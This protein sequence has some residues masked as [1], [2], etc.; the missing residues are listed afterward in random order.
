LASEEDIS[1]NQKLDELCVALD[2]RMTDDVR[3]VPPSVVI[4][5]GSG[6]NMLPDMAEDALK[7][8][9]GELPHVGS[10][11]VA[12]HGGK[13]VIGKV[14]GKKVVILGGRRHPYEG[15]T[16]SQSTLLLRAVIKLF[17]IRVVVLSNAAG[18]LNPSFNLAD[19][20]IVRD[21]INFMFENPLTGPNDDSTGK[22]FPDM[23]QA[24]SPRLIALAHA[25]AADTGVP[26]REGVYIAGKGPT[27]ETRAEMAMFRNIMGADS[28]GMSTVHETIAAKHA[29]C[30]VL[31]LSV[32]TN[33]LPPRDEV[34]H[35]EVM[36]T[37]KIAGERM[38]R[39]LKDFLTKL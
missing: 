5:A 6:L 22:R 31:C 10:V 19:I 20:M 35:A 8:D 21:H 15:I 18:G 7:L 27:Y 1:T 23:S 30:E 24:Y 25:A 3:K 34:T 38:V 28:I 26:V 11:T 12:G 9:Y 2:E 29:R 14:A 36:Q 17:G 33:L 37:G 4:V 39:L 16:L 13:L 32:I